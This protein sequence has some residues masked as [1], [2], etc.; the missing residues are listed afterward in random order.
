MSS[1][2]RNSFMIVPTSGRKHAVGRW[3]VSEDPRAGNGGLSASVAQTWTPGNSATTLM[4]PLRGS[5]QIT[6]VHRRVPKACRL[7]DAAW[8]WRCPWDVL[9]KQLPR[10]SEGWRGIRQ[11][12]LVNIVTVKGLCSE[13]VPH[14]SRTQGVPQLYIF[15]TCS[16]QHGFARFFMIISTVVGKQHVQIMCEIKLRNIPRVYLSGRKETHQHQRRLAR[17][18]SRCDVCNRWSLLVAAGLAAKASKS[19]FLTYNWSLY[20]FNGCEIPRSLTGKDAW[21]AS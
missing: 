7:D 4:A 13:A 2:G 10:S 20:T 11:M 15:S 14:V 1:M 19:D 3:Q 8:R 9:L 5:G 12:L 16:L 6:C 17:M 18:G 21:Y